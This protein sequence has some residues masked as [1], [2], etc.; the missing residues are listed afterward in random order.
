MPYCESALSAFSDGLIAF[1]HGEGAVGGTQHQGIGD[2]LFTGRDRGTAVDIEQLDL[3]QNIAYGTGDGLFD[4]RHGQ[5]IIADDGQI[6]DGGGETGQGVV[7]GLRQ[8]DSKEPGDIQPGDPGAVA[9]AEVFQHGG[10]DLTDRA[11]LDIPDGEDG[12]AAGVIAGW[13][14]TA[15]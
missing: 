2:A 3:L 7:G 12:I 1:L 15:V 14:E 6:A 4:D 10:V 13:V 11:D 9:D 5:G 8:A